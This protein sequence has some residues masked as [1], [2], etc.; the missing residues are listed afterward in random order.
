MERGLAVRRLHRVQPVPPIC[1]TSDL[2]FSGQGPIV[3]YQAIQRLGT[4]Q[5]FLAPSPRPAVA[6]IARPIL[7]DR[8][9]GEYGSSP[10]DTVHSP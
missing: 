2:S 5:T 10:R 4:F 9:A 7:A 1:R 3:L 6:P 8:G